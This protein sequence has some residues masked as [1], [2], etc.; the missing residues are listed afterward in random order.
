M[1]IVAIGDIGVVDNMIHVG[2]EAMFEQL[3]RE[4]RSRG[5]SD[6]V[7]LSANPAD[8]AARYDV[9]SIPRVGF[10][11]THEQMTER[12]R[13]VLS[14]RLP[15][16]DPARAVIE[17]V[18]TSGGVVIAG[19]G[20]MASL[21][22]M[23]IFE[24]ATL[25][26]LAK[27]AGVPLVV[28]GQ[29][30]GP[31]LTESDAALVK[32][33]LTSARL[34][35]VREEASLQLVRRLGVDSAV[36]TVDDASYLPAAQSTSPYCLVTLAGHVAGYDKGRVVQRIAELL[37][38]VARTTAL[39]IVFSPHFG[40]LVAG[41]VRGDSVMHAAVAERMSAASREIPATDAATSGA[42]ARGASLVVSSRY[43]PVIFAVPGGVPAIGI[44]VDDYTTVK[45]TGALG[46]FAQDSVLHVGALIEG[47]GTA[48]LAQVWRERDAIRSR[49]PNRVA[50][51][52]AWWDR[53]AAALS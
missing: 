16:S 18:E 17:A 4:L 43:H 36:L 47:A 52:S 5:V 53:V 37:D 33:L 13:T 48:M 1:H 44:A 50:Q 20:N 14:G 12:M 7:A 29:T 2:D 42:L 6:V 21:W 8:T 49:V 31:Q 27:R 32:E 25:A 26:A 46:N 35:G 38:E 19:G 10:S 9:G 39:D 3:V 45:L 22:P 11:G 51:S 28:S 24:R 41:D 34:V 30:I 40:S 15:T 23:H